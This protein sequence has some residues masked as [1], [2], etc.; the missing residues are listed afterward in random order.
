M[1]KHKTTWETGR[2]LCV[3]SVA[4][5]RVET[6]DHTVVR[7]PTDAW[8]RLAFECST[9]RGLMLKEALTEIQLFF[10]LLVENWSHQ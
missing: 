6:T 2:A 1:M 8:S 7:L 10:V 9:Q 4:G 5:L 3:F